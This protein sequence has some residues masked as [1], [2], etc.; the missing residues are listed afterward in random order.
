MTRRSEVGRAVTDDSRISRRNA[1]SSDERLQAG[2]SFR[3]PV[4]T[5]AGLFL[6][7]RENVPSHKGVPT[8]S[9][10]LILTALAL[11]A[12]T[13]AGCGSKPTS[14][15]VAQLQSATTTTTAAGAG[16]ATGGSKADGARQFSVCMRS[17]GL[18]NFPDPQPSGGGMA[19]SLDKASG[20]NPDSPQFKAA[21]KS[22]EKLLP[23]G[24]KPDAAMQAKAQAQLLKFSVCMRSHGVAN[25]PDPVFSN[26][27]A[28]V[29]LKS[30]KSS[31]NPN[32]P[33]FQAAQK[34]CQ[35]V[36]PGPPIGGKGGGATSSSS[37]GGKSAGG[38]PSA[39][40]SIAP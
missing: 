7:E 33:V 2:N 20:L 15:G 34:A 39:Q 8:M 37:G 18:P 27:S 25:F 11:L 9:R 13:A 12:V 32:S 23:N 5:G 4:V 28:K 3:P 22:C 24:G 6:A 36:M 16:S 40:M 31:L 19:L 35:S 10:I 14:S 21:Q 1:R 38:G 29:T 17:H 30:D 26:G